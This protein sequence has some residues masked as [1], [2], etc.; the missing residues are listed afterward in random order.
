[1]IINGYG[2]GEHSVFA[3]ELL[4]L[5]SGPTADSMVLMGRLSERAEA[6]TSGASDCVR[7]RHI[8]VMDAIGDKE[9]KQSDLKL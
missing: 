9:K 6:K 3:S 4:A 7:A 5:A 1:M 2:M 8:K